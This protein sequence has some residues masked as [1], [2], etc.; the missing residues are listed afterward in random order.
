M[1]IL[2]SKSSG[3]IDEGIEPLSSDRTADLVI[4]HQHADIIRFC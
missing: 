2:I 3:R 1:R 4:T